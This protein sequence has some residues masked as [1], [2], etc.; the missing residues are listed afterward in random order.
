MEDKSNVKKRRPFK[1]YAHAEGRKKGKKR[2]G[3]KREQ[4]FY[5]ERQVCA[6]GRHHTN[7]MWGKEKN[8]CHLGEKEG[9]E[10]GNGRRTSLMWG[11]RERRL[12]REGGKKK[13]CSL[14]GKGRRTRRGTGVPLFCE[15]KGKRARVHGL[16]RKQTLLSFWQSERE[17]KGKKTPSTAHRMKEGIGQQTRTRKKENH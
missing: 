16:G 10:K 6:K 2:G 14:L 13:A 3:R 7:R 1:P 15:K 11:G 12:E 4:D 5:L 9:K 17:R 8:G